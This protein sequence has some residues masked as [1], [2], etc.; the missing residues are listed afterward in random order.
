[1]SIREHVRRLEAALL[2]GRVPV[3][4]AKLYIG[5]GPSAWND[6]PMN[7][8]ASKGYIEIRDIED[9]DEVMN[10]GQHT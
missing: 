1:M 8:D 3:V 5:V 2:P 10:D 4:V 9:L 7:T 6:E